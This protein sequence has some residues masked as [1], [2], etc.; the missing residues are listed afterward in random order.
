MG[1]KGFSTG[2]IRSFYFAFITTGCA[3]GLSYYLLARFFPQENYRRFKG[4]RFREWTEEEVELYVKGAPWRILG[5]ASPKVGE[6]G[7]PIMPGIGEVWKM[8]KIWVRRRS[9]PLKPLFSR[10][11][12]PT[13]AGLQ[14]ADFNVQEFYLNDS[15]RGL[16]EVVL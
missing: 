4:L 2:V 1:V 8:W 12:R 13:P 6:D 3:S 7:V 5:T 16:S 9:I 10:C 14:K 11:K 15:Y